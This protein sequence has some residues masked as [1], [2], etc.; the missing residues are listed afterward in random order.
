MPVITVYISQ[1]SHA[2]DFCVNPTFLALSSLLSA[3]PLANNN[4]TYHLISFICSCVI[5]PGEDD[6]CT[7][8]PVITVY[9][10]QVSHA[11][12]FCFDVKYT[13][14]QLGNA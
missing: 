8:M 10:S 11:D 5:S 9:I 2:D 1:V 7:K 13:T 12:D 3:L 6:N 4:N 14:P